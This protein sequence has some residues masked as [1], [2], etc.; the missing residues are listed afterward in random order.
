MTRLA[1]QRVQENNFFGSKKNVSELETM[2]QK[3]N[4]LLC[5]KNKIKCCNY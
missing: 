1:D 2:F 3:N 4:H 5:S